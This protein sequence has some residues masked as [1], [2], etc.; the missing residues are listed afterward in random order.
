[1]TFLREGVESTATSKTLSTDDKTLPASEPTGPLSWKQQ[2]PETQTDPGL[3]PGHAPCDSISEP[4]ASRAG[5]PDLARAPKT[6]QRAK[7]T[8]KRPGDHVIKT[9]TNGKKRKRTEKKNTWGRCGR[10]ANGASHGTPSRTM[11]TTARGGGS[12][13]RIWCWT[14]SLGF[15]TELWGVRV[16][17]V[18]K[19]GP[20]TVF[21]PSMFCRCWFGNR[22]VDI[23]LKVKIDFNGLLSY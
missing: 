10:G 19:R 16:V 3:N 2:R 1:M 15:E 20:E 12:G 18:S 5:L 6:R 8:K 14:R 21:D 11:A 22:L 9:K 13:L 7:E 23:R 4:T 17:R